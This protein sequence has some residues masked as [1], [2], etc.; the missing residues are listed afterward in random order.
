MH[1]RCGPH[2]PATCGCSSTG[3]VPAF[4]AGC[5]GSSPSCRSMWMTHDWDWPDTA[6]ATLLLVMVAVAFVD[7][8]IGLIG[9]I[10]TVFCWGVWRGSD[11]H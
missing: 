9:G 8:G 11:R 3:R 7:F 6:F 1:L 10:A 2:G 5:E 4:Q